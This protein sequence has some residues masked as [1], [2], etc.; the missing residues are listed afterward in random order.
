M[1]IAGFKDMYEYKTLIIGSLKANHK[2]KN[3]IFQKAII[4]K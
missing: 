1:C 4:E 3:I 2:R